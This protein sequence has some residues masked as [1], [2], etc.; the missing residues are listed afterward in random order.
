MP[1]MLKPRLDNSSRSKEVRRKMKGEERALRAQESKTAS[2]SPETSADTV[3]SPA[4]AV[5]K[6]SLKKIRD[7][8]IVEQT[9]AYNPG[10]GKPIIYVR[11]RLTTAVRGKKKQDFMQTAA[12]LLRLEILDASEG[13]VVEGLFL[14]PWQITGLVL[15]PGAIHIAEPLWAGFQARQGENKGRIYLGDTVRNRVLD[16]PIKVSVVI[17]GPD[18]FVA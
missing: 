13:A 8:M 7:G 6:N 11:F 2:D 17:P 1:G 10:K 5:E 16:I 12:Y 3:M 9:V 15:E 14:G 18:A 4:S